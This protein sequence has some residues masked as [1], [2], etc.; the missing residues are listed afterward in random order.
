MVYTLTQM[1]IHYEE[2]FRLYRWID[3][4]PC[5]CSIA[6]NIDVFNMETQSSYAL[7][8][9]SALWIYCIC[10]VGMFCYEILEYE[11]KQLRYELKFEMCALRNCLRNNLM[12]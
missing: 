12:K 9:L 4:L 5:R 11:R 8:G 6:I 10:S 7:F 2:F 3:S 1:R